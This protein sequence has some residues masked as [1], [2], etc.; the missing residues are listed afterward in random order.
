MW[1]ISLFCKANSSLGRLKFPEEP[2]RG[3]NIILGLSGLKI[4]RVYCCSSWSWGVSMVKTSRSPGA[5]SF[6]RGASGGGTTSTFPVSQCIYSPNN[7]YLEHP[8]RLNREVYR[9][10][11]QRRALEV[12]L[13]EAEGLR[14]PSVNWS[15]PC[16]SSTARKERVMLTTE[17]IAFA[18]LLLWYYTSISLRIQC[19][20][21]SQSLS[22]M[23]LQSS[24]SSRFSAFTLTNYLAD[25][26]IVLTPDPVLFSH[27]CW[28]MI[29]LMPGV[30]G[31]RLCRYTGIAFSRGSGPC[32][33]KRLS[34]ANQ[35]SSY[36]A[37]CDITSQR[38]HFYQMTVI[39]ASKQNISSAFPNIARIWL[40]RSVYPS[41]RPWQTSS[42][43]VRLRLSLWV[44]HGSHERFE[45]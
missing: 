20:A 44:Y 10:R 15:D 13:V 38:Q 28:E 41:F 34:P 37:C 7:T 24:T 45:F 32:Q 26:F 35:I 2:W 33:A 8:R 16:Y 39:S 19:K 12:V 22:L 36:P 43:R 14:N 3:M 5:A 29:V 6:W 31:L 11:A 17:W 40:L 25:R 23:Y 9:Y 4:G 42:P 30:R 21:L 27:G 18:T 1:D